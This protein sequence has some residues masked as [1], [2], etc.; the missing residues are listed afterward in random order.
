MTLIVIRSLGSA[1]FRPDKVALDLLEVTA[2]VTVTAD[3][4]HFTVLATCW[5]IE[6]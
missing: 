4:G 5:A 6:V 2:M 1:R 3:V